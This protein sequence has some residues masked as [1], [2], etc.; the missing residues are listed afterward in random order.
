M[1]EHLGGEVFGDLG[2]ALTSAF[3]QMEWAEEEIKRAERRHPAACDAIWH[4][5]SLLVSTHDLMAHEQVFR[6]HCRELLNRVAAGEDTRLGTAAELCCT[7]RDV[8]LA[9]PV[10]TTATGLYFRMFR[11]AFPSLPLDADLS[12]YEA[13][14][15]T[16]MDEMEADTR[17]RLAV[18]DR[19]VEGV[20]CMGKHHG[21]PVA[22]RFVV[23]E[24]EGAAA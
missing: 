23:R 5:F 6:A 1:T 22:C 2:A 3:D 7:F 11:S 16:Q 21:K 15:G 8:T 10:N 4:S 9:T 24:T 17:R 13:L 12:H 19:H 18:A 20:E 14:R